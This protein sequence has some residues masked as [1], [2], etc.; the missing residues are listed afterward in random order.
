MTVSSR[1]ILCRL[2]LTLA[3]IGLIAAA[4]GTGTLVVEVGNVRSAAGNIHVDVCPQSRF[5]KEDCPFT[6]EAPAHLGTTRLLIR[7][8]PAGRYAVQVTHDENNNHK[9]DRNI[10]GIPTEG[11]GFSRDARI[12]LGPPKWDDAQVLFDGHAGTVSFP[13]HYFL[14]RSGPPSR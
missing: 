1:S 5:L 9:V 6:T 10:L 12:R 3:S 11:I 4:P 8:L 2:F 7:G 13:L 14:G